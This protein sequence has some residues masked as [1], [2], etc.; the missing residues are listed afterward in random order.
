VFALAALFAL[1][2]LDISVTACTR[3]EIATCPGQGIP[4]P[5]ERI[6]LD[7]QFGK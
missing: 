1:V 5:R 3:A 7:D 4:T 2:Y 6:K